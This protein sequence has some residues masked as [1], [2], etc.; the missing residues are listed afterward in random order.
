MVDDSIESVGK[1]DT[2]NA[3]RRLIAFMAL[4]G[5]LAGI[6][7]QYYLVKRDAAL[8]LFENLTFSRITVEARQHIRRIEYGIKHG[9]ELEQFHNLDRILRDIQR[10]SSYITGVYVVGK[11]DALLY[12]LDMDSGGVFEL[13][14]PRD[15]EFSGEALYRMMENQGYFDLFMPIYD[16]DGRDMAF[17]I[18]RLDRDVVFFS[19]RGLISQEYMQSLVIALLLLGIGLIIIVKKKTKA[20][21]TILL[22]FLLTFVGLSMDL[23][24]AYSRYSGIAESAT[25]QSVNRIAQLLQSDV[26][27]I[28]AMGVPPDAIHDQ[29]SWLRQAALGMPMIHSGSIDSNMRITLTASRAYYSQYTISLLRS[30]AA[31]YALLLLAAAAAA[32]MVS[33]IHKNYISKQ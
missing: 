6:A 7:V 21:G 12:S 10:S 20:G 28:R 16:A 33:R 31:V 1:K 17:V 29:N 22:I 18:I 3:L 14:R 24:L 27:V 26:E 4:A 19:T 15:L 25:I 9:R 11:Q 32:I 2:K 5:V 8:S 23:G 13:R 30:Y